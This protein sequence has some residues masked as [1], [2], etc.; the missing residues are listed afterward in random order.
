MLRWPGRRA[1]AGPD[2]VN[3]SWVAHMCHADLGPVA[4]RVKAATAAWAE[5]GHRSAETGSPG[6]SRARVCPWGGAPAFTRRH[7]WFSI[8]LGPGGIERSK[9]PARGDGQTRALRL[10]RAPGGKGGELGAG[11]KMRSSCRPAI[12]VRTH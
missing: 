12:R 7:L 6:Q 11:I 2:A 10:R 1:G 3:I 5:R 9:A 4:A 8:S